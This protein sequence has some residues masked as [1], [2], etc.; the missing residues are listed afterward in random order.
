MARARSGSNGNGKLDKL[1]EA[2]TSLVQAQAQLVQV[3]SAT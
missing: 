2:M 3:Q 1:D